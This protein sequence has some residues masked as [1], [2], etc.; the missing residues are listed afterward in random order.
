MDPAHPMRQLFV[1]V[2]GF[3][4]WP[5]FAAFVGWIIVRLYFYRSRYRKD[6]YFVCVLLGLIL[7]VYFPINRIIL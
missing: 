5:V 1:M 4:I 7:A 2:A 6:I 3:I